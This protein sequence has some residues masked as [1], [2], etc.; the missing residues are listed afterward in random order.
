MINQEGWLEQ[1]NKIPSP[2]FDDRPKNTEIKLIVIHNISLP[3][4]NFN[5]SN[6]EKL[7]LNKLDFD[8]HEYFKEI[9]DLKVSS[10][11]LIDREGQ[12]TQFVSVYKRAWHAG[13]SNFEN[14]DNCNDFSIGIEM[15]GSDNSIF[16]N[17]QYA[18]LK[19]LIKS[20]KKVFPKIL[21]DNIV[22]HS[23]IAPGRK[24]DPGPFFD[25]TKIR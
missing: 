7:F 17:K 20:L 15:I 10:H 16:E 24:T 14:E 13:K 23:D 8:S 5:P 2:N 25:W 18:S 6:I 21:E 4:E 1:S 9:R 22:G 11:F 12:I 19:K 3:P